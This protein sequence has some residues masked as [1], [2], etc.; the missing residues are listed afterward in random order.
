AAFRLAKH[1]KIYYQA[2]ASLVHLA[3]PAG[4]TRIFVPYFDNLNFYKNDLL[5]MAKTVRIYNWP[6]ALAKRYRDALRDTNAVT[7]L[8]RSG[9][10][11]AG[12]GR[13]LYRWV[14]PLKL[15]QQPQKEALK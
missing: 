2:R 6:I 9:L 13:G 14:M 1:G 11:M 7:K 3:A 10:F 15:E 12:F 8:Y 4:G 5:F